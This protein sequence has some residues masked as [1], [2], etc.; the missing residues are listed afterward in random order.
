LN[1]Y[2]GINL[3]LQN[4]QSK[5]NLAIAT[6]SWD[7]FARKMLNHCNI[8]HYF[9]PVVGANTYGA[10]KPDPKMLHKLLETLKIDPKS[11]VLVGDSLK[12]EYAAESANIPFIYVGWGYGIYDPKTPYVANSS[13]ELNTLLLDFI[14]R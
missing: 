14:S 1:L 5:T 6:N 12:D 13:E 11:A 9:D 8:G 10:P 7:F 2:K 3:L 4:L